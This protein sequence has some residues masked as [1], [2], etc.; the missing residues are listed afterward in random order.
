MKKTISCNISGIIFNLEEDAYQI[1]YQYL[2][3]LKNHLVN[4]EGGDEIYN[5]IELRIAELFSEKLKASKQVITLLEVNEVIQTI[6]DPEDYVDEGEE[7]EYTKSEPKHKL[8]MR[9]LDRRVIG[10]VCGG[11]SNYFGIDIFLIR[12]LFVILFLLP[13]FGLLLYII[14]WVITPAAKTSADRLKMKG[15]PINLGSL[16]DE[17]KKAAENVEQY[18]QS[19]WN[20][21]RLER[22][23]HKTN[24]VGRILSRLFGF[25]LI[26]AA[27]ASMVTFLVVT[28]TEVG[29]FTSDDG[30]QLISLY[31]FS[32]VIFNSPFQSFLGWS[33]LLGT[34]MIPLI[35][36]LMLGL[37]LFFHLRSTWLKYAM[38]GFFILWFFAIGVLT[39][40]GIQLGREFSYK[41]ESEQ[42]FESIY[43]DQLIVHVPS[44]FGAKST[45]IGNIEINEHTV[46]SFLELE[47][48]NVKSGFVALEIKSSKD[49]LFHV[50]REYSAYGITQQKAL[51]IAGNIDHK[52]II[53]DNELELEPFYKFPNE[54][55]LRGQFVKVK[56]WVPKG[57]KI[58]WKGNKR[59]IKITNNTD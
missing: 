10:G 1:L 57:K 40:A 8:F 53:N 5:D 6:G 7:N 14:L 22:L 47:K 41:G 55:K 26:F 37:S 42:V 16:K 11:I 15:E 19:K 56:I 12:A 52:L 17:V 50:T 13:G 27:T 49:S 4:T 39:V 9:D 48:G 46:S 59:Q 18:S 51:R 38:T 43:S 33:G 28:L 36:I 20:E 54:D 23:R 58:K 24:K 32:G 3:N 35:F 44:A 25:F 34:V 21:H 2:T 29:I 31:E 45:G 30:E